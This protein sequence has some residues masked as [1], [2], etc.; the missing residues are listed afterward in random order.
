M[1]P[2]GSAGP[3]KPLSPEEQIKLMQQAKEERKAATKRERDEDEDGVPEDEDEGRVLKK[4]AGLIMKRPAKHPH[5]RPPCPQQMGK[6][7]YYNGGK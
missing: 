1:Q 7:V 4:P 6:A 5:L 3:P 2:M